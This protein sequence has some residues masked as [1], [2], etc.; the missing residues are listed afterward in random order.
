M[1]LD[2]IH[3]VR[4]Q[5]GHEFRSVLHHGGR[6]PFA[7]DPVEGAIPVSSHMRGGFDGK[8][9]KKREKKNEQG[10]RSKRES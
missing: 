1:F 5:A 2:T 3:E 7:S 8:W 4:G 10:G 9:A 6:F